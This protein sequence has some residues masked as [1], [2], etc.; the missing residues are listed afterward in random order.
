MEKIYVGFNED[1]L[2]LIHRLLEWELERQD[3]GETEY[4]DNLKEIINVILDK[5]KE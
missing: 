1:Q 2:N 3:E 4:E 5:V